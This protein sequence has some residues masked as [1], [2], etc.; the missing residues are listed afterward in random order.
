MDMIEIYVNNIE[1]SL[2]NKCY[3]SALALPDM[4]GMAEFPEE[5]SVSKRYIEWYAKRKPLSIQN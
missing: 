2:K 1:R 4:C 3:F 5:Q